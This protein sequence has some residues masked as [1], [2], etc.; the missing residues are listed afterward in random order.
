MTKRSIEFAALAIALTFAGACKGRTAAWE[1]KNTNTPTPAGGEATAGEGAAGNALDAGLEAW[2]ARVDG[3]EKVLEAVAA[4]EGALGCT[5]GDGTPEERCANP[6]I[7]AENIEVLAMLTRGYYF[8]G[9]SY[10]R[11]DEKKYLD[12]MNRAVWWGE[13]A[14][15][16]ASPEFRE[17]MANKGKFHEAIG[18]VGIEAL[19]AMYWYA[20]ALGKWARASGFG[21]LVGQ[22]DNI[23]ATM[24]RALELDP[25]YYHGGPH[26]YFGA[27]YAV[28]PAFAG[29]DLNTSQEHYGKSLELAPYFLG[30]K[31]LMAENLA[32]KLDD[33]EMFDRLLEEVLAADPNAAPPEILAE[34]LVEQDKARELQ[35]IKDEEDWF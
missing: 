21:V 2:N 15:M 14:L 25:N 35:K 30:T 26:R 13:R 23:K 11:G 28:A 19:P 27:F 4:W 29:G 24:T 20:T 5:A 1:D 3:K 34:M 16:A 22:K 9:D 17:K 7:T 33:E 18:V 10:L 6:P 32:T 8:Y 12:T 31:V